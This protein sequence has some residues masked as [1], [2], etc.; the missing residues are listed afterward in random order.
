MKHESVRLIFDLWSMIFD[1]LNRFHISCDLRLLAFKRGPYCA[2]IVPRK[3]DY[4]LPT[5][6]I[7]HRI[8]PLHYTA[9]QEG[10]Q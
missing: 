6:F 8:L 1:Q 2:A 7:I 10:Q 3:I 5:V 9:L 4:C